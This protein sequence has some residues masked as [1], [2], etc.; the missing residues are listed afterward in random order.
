M[1]VLLI[2][3]VVD[4]ALSH[5]AVAKALT[6]VAGLGP[7]DVLVAGT[8]GENAAAEAATLAGVTK[9]LFAGDHALCHGLAEPTA[10]LVQALAPGYTHIAAASTAFGKSSCPA[11][12]P[13]S[14][15]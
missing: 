3:E 13:C 15:S 5:D 11:L 9:V 10:A 7:V 12:L 14:T 4:G 6:A 8:G 1:A 2:A